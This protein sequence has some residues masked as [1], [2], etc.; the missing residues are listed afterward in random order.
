M[1]AEN[2]LILSLFRLA[3]GDDVR[4]E[5]DGCGGRGG[6]ALLRDLGQPQVSCDWLAGVVLT[7]DWSTAT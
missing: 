6:D 1:F 7:S 5:R 4:G 2:I 3:A